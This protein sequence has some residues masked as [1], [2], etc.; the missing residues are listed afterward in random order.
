MFKPFQIQNVEKQ[1]AR[2]KHS[3]GWLNFN[4]TG[5]KTR[6]LTKNTV[7]N[8]HVNF[9]PCFVPTLQL[10]QKTPFDIR[11]TTVRSLLPSGLS[12]QTSSCDSFIGR[13]WQLYIDTADEQRRPRHGHFADYNWRTGPTFVNYCRAS[14]VRLRRYTWSGLWTDVW[15]QDLCSTRQEQTIC[16]E[17][18]G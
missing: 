18:A 3:H 6:I 12:D 17:P 11:W 2:S 10:V 15:L 9:A 7:F 13:L 1:V 4:K 14:T 5:I 16:S 8:M